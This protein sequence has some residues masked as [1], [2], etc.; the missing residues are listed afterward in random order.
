MVKNKRMTTE[1]KLRPYADWPAC[2]GGPRP[3]PVPPH[4]TEAVARGVIT[5]F[6]DPISSDEFP[7]AV[8][9]DS[10]LFWEIAE[11]GSKGKYVCHH[12]VEVN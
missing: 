1:L 9:C 12:C 6:L 3:R 7:F 2:D 4:L 11:P 5:V 8:K 10:P